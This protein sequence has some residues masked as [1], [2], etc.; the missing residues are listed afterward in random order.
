MDDKN[1]RPFAEADSDD[2]IKK[3]KR[4]QEVKSKTF[5]FEPPFSDTYYWLILWN[6]YSKKTVSTP[7]TISSANG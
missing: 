1:Y 2:A 6:T 7:Y 4:L 5:L 3:T